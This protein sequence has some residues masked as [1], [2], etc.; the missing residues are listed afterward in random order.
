MHTYYQLFHSNEILY[1]LPWLKF[2]CYFCSLTLL[3]SELVFDCFMNG[4][5][6]ESLL[7]I[8]S[9]GVDSINYSLHDF[10]RFVVEVDR[11]S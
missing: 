5:P 6:A 1:I 4:K 3:A 11:L 7:E 8:L 2:H 10:S 9:V